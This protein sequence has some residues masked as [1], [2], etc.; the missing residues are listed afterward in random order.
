MQ[1]ITLISWHILT[2]FHYCFSVRP[3]VNASMDCCKPVREELL[4]NT[5]TNVSSIMQNEGIP[6]VVV[7]GTALNLHRDNALRN[8]DD[9]VDI[10]IKPEDAHRVAS[11]FKNATGYPIQLSQRSMRLDG[12]KLRALGRDWSPLDIWIGHERDGV[13]CIH[14]H[15]YWDQSA[16]FSSFLYPARK[17]VFDIRGQRVELSLP[18]DIESFL[19]HYY[20]KDWKI[21]RYYKGGATPYRL[22]KRM[23]PKTVSKSSI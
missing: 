2:L 20:G 7:F 19:E 6:F 5:L 17:R 14:A 15:N 1:H 22:F 9:D 8:Q 11:A 16:C 4:L 3:Q 13:V 10:L 23:C 21:P 18:R 12:R